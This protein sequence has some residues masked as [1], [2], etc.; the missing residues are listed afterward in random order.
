MSQDFISTLL[1]Y[2]NEASVS[3]FVSRAPWGMGLLSIVGTCPCSSLLSLLLAAAG[4]TYD[5]V[6][7]AFVE[8][9]MHRL[10]YYSTKDEHQ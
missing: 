10:E 1:F 8:D 2:K 3:V 5:N 6:R 7:F 4:K 9:V